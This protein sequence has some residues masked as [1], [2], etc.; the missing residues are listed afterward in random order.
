MEALDYQDYLRRATC[1][2]IERLKWEATQERIDRLEAERIAAIRWA[3]D[4]RT[5]EIRQE[6]AI[7][8]QRRLARLEADRLRELIA[9]AN[10]NLSSRQPYD[11]DELDAL[12]DD[13]VA[14]RKQAA[15]D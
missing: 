4:R 12:I 13:E 11:Y 3:I 10:A 9:R 7:A 2:R 6:K 8:T 14:A 5:D 15:R 1:D